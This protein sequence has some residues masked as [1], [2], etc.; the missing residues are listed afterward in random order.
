MVAALK[1]DHTTDPRDDLL[2]AVGSIDHLEVFGADVLV[3]IYKRPEKTA[4]GVILSDITRGEDKWQGK[5]GLVLKK[6]PAAFKDDNNTSFHGADVDVG[7]WVYFR[8][9]D[10]WSLTVNKCDC[11]MLQDVHIKGRVPSPDYVW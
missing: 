3:A 1:M 7:D 10:G 2:K 5:V 11:R 6:G 9:S 4:G 8:V